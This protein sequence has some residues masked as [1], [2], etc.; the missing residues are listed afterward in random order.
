MERTKL[1]FK[2]IM[3][4]KKENDYFNYK[5]EDEIKVIDNGKDADDKIEKDYQQEDD[6]FLNSHFLHFKPVFTGYFLLST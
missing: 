6:E 2:E 5:G 4:N 1:K 3:H